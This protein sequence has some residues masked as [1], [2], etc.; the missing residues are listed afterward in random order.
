MVWLL[1]V[2]LLFMIF[3]ILYLVI[4]TIFTPNRKIEKARKHKRF[5]LLDND[6]V[7]KNFQLTYNGAVFTG[8]KYLGTAYNTIDVVSITIWPQS[9]TSLKG[10]SKDDFYF[11]E[12]KILEKYPM[13]KINWKSPI[14]EFLQ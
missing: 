10:L 13:A 6:D 1:R 3:F 5:L 4:R 9:T 8:E 11:I 2:V 14:Y 7:V 12:K